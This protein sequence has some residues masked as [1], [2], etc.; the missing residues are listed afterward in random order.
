[1]IETNGIML[2][3]RA[4]IVLILVAALSGYTTVPLSLPKQ[5]TSAIT[6][7]YDTYFGRAAQTLGQLHDSQSGFCSTAKGV[8][9]ATEV[10]T[11]CP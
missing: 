5:S 9:S 3:A 1:M 7:T 6:D 8:F 10:L 2:S 4:A 11:A